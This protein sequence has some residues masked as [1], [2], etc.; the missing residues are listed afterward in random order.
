[1]GT[2]ETSEGEVI[3]IE[4]LS[5]LPKEAS[6][7]KELLE[8]LGV[9]SLLAVPLNV[10]GRLLGFLVLADPATPRIWG[11]RV[12]KLLQIF[13]IVLGVFLNTAGLRRS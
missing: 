8:E 13:A 1:M 6:A 9:H 10:T 2:R 7:E 12:E 3:C 11:K 4:D 5:S